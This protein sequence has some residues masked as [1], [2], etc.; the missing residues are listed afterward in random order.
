[1]YCTAELSGNHSEPEEFYLKYKEKQIDQYDSEIAELIEQITNKPAS[2]KSAE[3]RAQTRKLQVRGL[4]QKQQMSLR[5]KGQAAE[6]KRNTRS[7]GRIAN[8][9]PADTVF[10]VKKNWDCSYNL[11]D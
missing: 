4:Q 8:E 5:W 9:N 6:E 7:R 3:K 10:T 11:I 1:M 2:K